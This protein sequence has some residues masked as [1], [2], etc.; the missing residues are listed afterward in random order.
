LGLRVAI[1]SR[2]YGSRGQ[3]HN[4][5]ALELQRALP[6]VPH[7]QNPDRVAAAERAI[8]EYDCQ[9]VL[10]DDGFQHRRLARDLDIVLVDALEPFGFDHV[11]PRGTLREPLTSL[12]R[13]HVVCLTRGDTI[14]ADER[15]AIRS[16]VVEIAPQA[17]WCESTHR[18]SGLVNAAGRS[19]PL[20][21]L[22][23]R[24]VMAFC[25][26]GNP[27]GFRHT[28]AG[29]GCQIVAWRE[30]PDHHPFAAS[31]IAELIAL[32]E[33]CRAELIVCTQKDLV[34]FERDDLAG[35]P[36]WAIEIETQFLA[37]RE[38]LE[39]KVLGVRCQCI[40]LKPDTRNLF[41]AAR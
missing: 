9:V 12:R 33:G 39:E 31:S 17:V 29:T 18:A 38:E 16:R 2:G 1:V 21:T 37:G 22:A 41:T 30:F 24:R 26:I 11:F 40:D 5:E 20:A 28:L 6:N 8:I 19:E 23:G 27:A 4:D 34:K 36:L 10:L 7:V 14:S 13:A 3:D 32:V 15:K 35:R 25:G